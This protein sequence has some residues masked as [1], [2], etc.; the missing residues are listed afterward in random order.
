MFRMQKKQ[1]HQ[2]TTWSLLEPVLYGLFRHRFLYLALILLVMVSTSFRM[3]QNK[4]QSAKAYIALN[5]EEATKG[6]YPNQTRFNIS[7]IKSDE[8]L[9][10][11]IEKAGLEDEITPQEMASNITAWAANVNG[12]QLPSGTTNYKIATTYTVTYTRNEALSRRISTKDMLRLIVEAY[13]E[14]FYEK[15]TYV[16][17]ALA[18]DWD[19][20]YDQEYMEIGTY[21]R[22]ECDKL[23]RFLSSRADENGTFRSASTGD[24]FVS[25]R[26]KVDNFI[27]ID[28]EKYDSYVLQ[29]GLSKNRERYVSK[30]NYQNFLKNIDYQKYM[31]EYQNRLHTID[32]YDSALTAVVLIPTLDAQ[33]NFYM[34]RTKVA[35][36]YQAS[37]AES[38]N[39]SANNVLSQIQQ[40]DYTI[41][42]MQ[43]STASAPEN[44]RTA[45]T[46]I[47][48][49]KT[50]LTGIVDTTKIVNK[51]YVR[52]KTKNY[53]TVTFEQLSTSDELS[54]K[55]ALLSGAMTLCA[56]SL[57][58]LFRDRI[59]DKGDKGDKGK[60]EK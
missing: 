54:V 36:D 17:V 56:I 58:I 43:A 33:D 35:I 39:A 9:S 16:D 32:I 47:S 19:E 5:Y 1:P 11:A 41:R 3:Y 7:L 10:R 14:V 46:M 25:L 40:N 44:I 24:S 8:V 28:L 53:L 48:A 34:S 27:N 37:A 15:Y 18:P 42:Q 30:L 50:K 55:W 23:R 57:F 29:S 31:A 49:M 52:Y 45:M 2:S 4:H 38:A 20:C 51:E 6:L 60:K 59:R 22:K 12:M 13:K 26:Q 21:F